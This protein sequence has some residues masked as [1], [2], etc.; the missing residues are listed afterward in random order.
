MGLFAAVGHYLVTSSV[1]VFRQKYHA[2]SLEVWDGRDYRRI[3]SDLPSNDTF[4]ITTSKTK[5]VRYE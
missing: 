5:G 2:A 4:T 3:M 1:A